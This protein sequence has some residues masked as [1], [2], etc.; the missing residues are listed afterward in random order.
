MPIRGDDLTKYSDLLDNILNF[1]PISKPNIEVAHEAPP[2]LG[3]VTNA[4]KLL[5]F[6]KLNT[7]NQ[8]LQDKYNE[9][10]KIINPVTST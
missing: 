8:E 9:V 3:D 2:N 10:Y 5:K 1:K 4:S 6:L 7:K